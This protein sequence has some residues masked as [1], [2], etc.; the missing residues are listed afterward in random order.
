[1]CIIKFSTQQRNGIY[2]MTNNLK[3]ITPIEGGAY[4]FGVFMI[5]YNSQNFIPLY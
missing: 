4:Y 3:M 5:L 2:N 1:M